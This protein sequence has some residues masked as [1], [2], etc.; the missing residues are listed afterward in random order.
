M[1]TTFPLRFGWMVGIGGGVPSSEND[2]RLGDVVFSDPNESHG[3]V[4][5]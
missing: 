1:L 4:L 5:Q 2:I 3:G